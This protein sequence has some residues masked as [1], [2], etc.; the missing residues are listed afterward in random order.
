M[1]PIKP[2]WPFLAVENGSWRIFQPKEEA[3]DELG[4]YCGE[5]G[6]LVEKS[7]IRGIVLYS[8]TDEMANY[9]LSGIRNAETKDSE[10]RIYTETDDLVAAHGIPMLPVYRGIFD[11]REIF[12]LSGYETPSAQKNRA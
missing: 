11:G 8:L 10:I 4:D 9:S 2:H 1:H 12:Q 5:W 6:A 7:E 3:S